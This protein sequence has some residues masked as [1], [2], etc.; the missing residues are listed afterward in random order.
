M[1]PLSIFSIMGE[2]SN[3]IGLAWSLVIVSHFDY[4]LYDANHHGTLETNQCH[5]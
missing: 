2:K 1:L 4:L 5:F 3:E